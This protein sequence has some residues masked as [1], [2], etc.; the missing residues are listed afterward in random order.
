MQRSFTG[1]ESIKPQYA[2]RRGTSCVGDLVIYVREAMENSR[3]GPFIREAV[4]REI[5][6]VVDLSQED[7]LA[8]ATAVYERFRNPFID[9]RL[10]DI[11]MN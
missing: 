4:E 3:I 11:A 9:L 8:Y 1:Y 5:I 7:L 10:S 2:E 6:P